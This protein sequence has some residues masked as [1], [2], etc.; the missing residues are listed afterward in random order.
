MKVKIEGKV[1]DSD[2]EPVLLIF[3][4]NEELIDTIKNLTDMLK[5][6][7]PGTIRKMVIYP[8]TMPHK[9]AREFMD[10]FSLNAD[11]DGHPVDEDRKD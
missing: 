1:A 11:A 2:K 10:S 6:N 9:M 4:D 3:R 5:Y 8:D 7:G